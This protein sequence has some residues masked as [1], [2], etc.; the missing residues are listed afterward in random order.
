MARPIKKGLDYFPM[1]TNILSDLKVR[2]MKR[3][4][5]AESFLLYVTFL[6]DI[7]S[8]GFY[9]KADE[10]YIF[11]L[12]DQLRMSEEEVQTM[13]REMIHVGLFD[14]RLYAEKQ[15]LTSKRI[16]DCYFLTKAKRT[17]LLDDE[18][19]DYLLEKVNE[20]KTPV[21][22]VKTPEKTNLSTQRKEK[23]REE[24]NITTI[25]TNAGEA[26]K[27]NIREIFGGYRDELLADEDW[28]ASVVR[29]SGKG[30][31]IMQLLPDAM[32]MFDYHAISIGQTGECLPKRQ[33]AQHF[34]NWWR[35]MKFRSAAEM[36]E[37]TRRRNEV[38]DFRQ[39]AGARE[40][41]AAKSRVQQAIELGNSVAEKLKQMHDY[42]RNYGTTVIRSV[43]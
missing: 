5:G 6:C 42:E 2:R 35:C 4:Y 13:L 25:T 21:M 26:K 17:E 43:G 36:E 11:D 32:K 15:I 19:K 20:V 37:E 39:A 30:A 28:L 34:I 24:N 3:K 40:R 23:K 10:D 14:A 29:I 18:E 16:Q 27:F 1:Q 31:G 8:N 38:T 22:E 9:L 41:P 33:Y 7:Y 12:S